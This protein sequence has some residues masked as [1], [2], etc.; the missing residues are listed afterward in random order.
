LA[1]FKDFA[2]EEVNKY[3]KGLREKGRSIEITIE[4]DDSFFFG[5]NELVL[6]CKYYIDEDL[7]KN[8]ISYISDCLLF[9]E[10]I[11]FD[12]VD[13]SDYLEQITE[14][15]NRDYEFKIRIQRIIDEITI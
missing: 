5:I 7:T 11:Y 9:S 15:E 4:D 6:L 12:P 8:E 14:P 1:L 2:P 3:E 10:S 13:V